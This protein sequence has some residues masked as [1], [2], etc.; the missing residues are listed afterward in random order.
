[1]IDIESDIPIP[2][3]Q[4]GRTAKYPF[5]Q[6][7]PG[8]SFAVPVGSEKPKTVINRLNTAAHGWRRRNQPEARFTVAY[9]EQTGKVRIWKK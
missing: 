2:Q 3:R 6:M 9:E 5:S 1:M 7:K 4:N 8:D